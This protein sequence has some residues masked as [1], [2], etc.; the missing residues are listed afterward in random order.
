MNVLDSLVNAIGQC[1]LVDLSRD[2]TYHAGGPFA[3]HIEPLE[4]EP[5]A[6]FFIDQVLPRL[7]PEAVGQVR[8]ENFPA[9]AFLRHELVTA[10]THAGSHVDAPGHY[11]PGIAQSA[12]FINQAPLNI[13]IAPGLLFDA[14]SVAGAEVSLADWQAISQTPGLAEVTGKIVLIRTGGNKA[15]SVKIIESLLDSGVQVIGTD[16]ESFDGEF[17]PMLKTFLATGDSSSLWPC[18][19][20]GRQRPYYQLERLGGLDRL[21]PTGFLVLALPIRIEGATAAWTRAIALVPRPD[22][23]GERG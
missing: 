15:I 19:F 12:A 20:L 11:G 9:G 18:H 17:Q 22:H 13:F 1:D 8:R 6:Q 14:S 23:N 5:G 7:L 21:P 3:T 2:V 16:G 10:S 4:P